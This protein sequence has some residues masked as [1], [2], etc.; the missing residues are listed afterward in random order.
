MENQRVRGRLARRG[1]LTELQPDGVIYHRHKNLDAKRTQNGS[2]HAIGSVTELIPDQHYRAG[3][4]QGKERDLSRLC[5]YKASEAGIFCRPCV[6]RQ[7][8][9]AAERPELSAPSLNEN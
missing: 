9:G 7:C 2:I 4:L 1:Q 5:C 3:E 6:W 8:Q